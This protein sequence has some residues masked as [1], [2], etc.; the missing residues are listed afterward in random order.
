MARTVKERSVLKKVIASTILAWVVV[1]AP[2]EPSS[3]QDR[4]SRIEM[5]LACEVANRLIPD[6][7][8]TAPNG[9]GWIN[10]TWAWGE[11]LYGVS[12]DLFSWI[13]KTESNYELSKISEAVIQV[14]VYHMGLH[15]ALQTI[16][17]A[18]AEAVTMLMPNKSDLPRNYILGMER[19]KSLIDPICRV[20]L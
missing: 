15:Y 16:Q 10:R 13:F 5:I 14:D 19:V 2:V 18:E 12:R 6:L 3:G 4:P 9:A 17:Y 8:E 7:I 1:L 20:Y 11:N